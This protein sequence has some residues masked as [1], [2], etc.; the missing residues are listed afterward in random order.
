[1]VAFG[2]I[3]G[4]VYLLN[5]QNTFQLSTFL[6]NRLL[7]LNHLF[8]VEFSI[9]LSSQRYAY[10][11]VRFRDK[12]HLVRFRKASVL[13]FNIPDLVAMVTVGG[14]LTS[15]E[16]IAILTTTHYYYYS[17]I[18]S[19]ETL[20]PIF[21][22]RP[23]SSSSSPLNKHFYFFILLYFFLSIYSCLVVVNSLSYC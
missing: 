8:Q 14:S 17:Y 12:N 3:V 21:L 15:Q 9:S 23:I 11:L 7:M 13:W 22:M 6:Q 5:Q 1:M 4:F 16:K 19:K 2:I 18:L 10:A 20:K